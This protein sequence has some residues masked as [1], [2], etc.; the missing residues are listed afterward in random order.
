MGREMRGGR[1]GEIGKGRKKEGKNDFKKGKE[2]EMTK[3]IGGRGGKVQNEGGE[4]KIVRGDGA[5][6]RGAI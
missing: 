2:E 4:E 3:I 1:M 5:E 6:K